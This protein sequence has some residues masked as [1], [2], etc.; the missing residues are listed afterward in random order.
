M[1]TTDLD[2][3]YQSSYNQEAAAYDEARF[4]S[5]RGEFAMRYKNKLAIELLEQFGA[6]HENARLLDC[7]SGTG[8]LTHALAGSSFGHIDAV[9][10]S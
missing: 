8:R 5:I 7:P 6:L 2:D 10:I 1:K 3:N 9:D 4:G